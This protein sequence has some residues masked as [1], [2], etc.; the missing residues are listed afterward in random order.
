MRWEA[1]MSLMESAGQVRT[2]ADG[3]LVFSE[4]S[5]GEHM[6]VVLE[7]AVRIR[8]EGGLVNTVLGEFGPGQMF[9]ELALVEKK[10]HSATAIASGPTK[11]LMHDRETF[12]GALL[13]DPEVALEVIWSLAAR[14]R[15]TTEK[16]QMIATQHVLDRAEMALVQKAVLESDLL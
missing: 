5:T 9:G 4:G 11:V 14:L 10:P 13:E 12:Q 7:G 8:K 3:E 2:F 16:L 1:T 6:Y 15:D